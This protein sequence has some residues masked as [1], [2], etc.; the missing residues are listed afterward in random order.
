[1]ENFSLV[2]DDAPTVNAA[3]T[4]SAAAAT[5]DVAALLDGELEFH[6]VF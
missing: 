5:V 1:M 4:A 3:A 2:L 6:N